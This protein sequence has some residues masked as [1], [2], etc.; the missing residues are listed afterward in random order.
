MRQEEAEQPRVVQVPNSKRKGPEE[1]AEET[2]E[3]TQPLAAAEQSSQAHPSEKS[4]G[5]RP[6]V[7]PKVGP[8]CPSGIPEFRLKESNWWTVPLGYSTRVFSTES[9]SSKSVRLAT[10]PGPT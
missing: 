8:C 7:G 2:Q 5:V 6:S 10:V 4:S 9:L 1:A 3:E